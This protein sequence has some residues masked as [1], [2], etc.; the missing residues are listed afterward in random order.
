[1]HR[2]V[3]L[4]FAI[5]VSLVAVAQAAPA[6]TVGAA[7]THQI[8]ATSS[9]QVNTIDI[10]YDA[11]LSGGGNMEGQTMYISIADEGNGGVGPAD[12]GEPKIVSV[13]GLTGTVWAANNTG[14]TYVA[15]LEQVGQYDITTAT[16][17]V[18]ATGKAF[19]IT[20]DRNGAATG[21][22]WPLRVFITVPGFGGPYSS[23]WSQGA[24][25][26]VFFT[27]SNGAFQY[28]PEPSSMVLGLFAAAGL[29]VV[30]LRRRRA[31]A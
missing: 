8:T 14:F 18:S 27:G 7:S 23:N 17:T 1:M 13:D 15:L 29:G 30:A 10:N 4:S 16:G 22:S 19:S 28:V 2:S 6:I 24:S 3:T 9:G 31:G 12:A 21:S 26:G 25:I 20:I 5:L 11:V